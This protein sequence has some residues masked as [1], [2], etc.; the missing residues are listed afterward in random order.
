[1]DMK[2]SL[3]S[4]FLLCVI[5][6]GTQS[7]KVENAEPGTESAIGA[8]AGFKAGFSLME[9]S[10][11]FPDAILEMYT[12]LNNQ[13]FGPGRIPFEFNIK[14]YPFGEEPGHPQLFLITN[15]A[16]PVG[17]QSP[18]FQLELKEGTYRTVAFLVDS[19]GFCLKEFGN[20]VDRDF[21]VGNSRPFPYS[22]EPFIAL[23]LP[24]NNQAYTFGED[25][26]VDFLVIGG[27]MLMD[28]L[29]V[30][31]KVGEQQ[32]EMDDVV[33]LRIS[34]LPRGEHLIQLEL[35][36]QNGKVFEG[37][38]SSVQKTILVQ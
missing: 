33:P 22:A 21:L 7:T 23:N 38:F 16:D 15:G 3:L 20:Y 32:F 37:P 28:Q 30:L 24:R 10:N 14:N 19:Q 12:P 6:C 29:K 26:V 5:G 2:K 34:D 1:M 27:D 36:K 4:C 31:V 35:R 11:E 17:H 9:E 8:N 25:V 13:T 18:M